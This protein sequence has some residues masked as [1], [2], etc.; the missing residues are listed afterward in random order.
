MILKDYD[1]LPGDA[2][3]TYHDSWLS[4][5]ILWFSKLREFPKDK[6]KIA[7]VAIFIKYENGIPII[8]EA[9]TRVI[10]HSG[11]CYNNKK[12]EIH[13]AR[14]KLEI[15][16]QMAEQIETYM[17]GKAGEGYAYIQLLA[18]AIQKIF[19]IPSVGDWDK[20]S[21]VCSE[22]Y[23]EIFDDLFKFIVCPGKIPAGINP[24]EIYE[25]IKMGKIIPRG[26]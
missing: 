17:K 20:G 4:K 19:G 2:I 18:L 3:F 1:L 5:I 10:L 26:C 23:C 21:V 15:T 24:L 16:P 12:Y 6:N 7:H 8:A 22:L 9:A 14:P 13:V 11:E 25:S